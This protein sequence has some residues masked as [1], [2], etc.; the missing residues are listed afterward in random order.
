M[1]AILILPA[2]YA[3][4]ILWLAFCGWMDW[5]IYDPLDD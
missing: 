4:L 1:T 3:A 5:P 2:I